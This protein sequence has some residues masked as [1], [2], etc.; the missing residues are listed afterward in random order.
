VSYQKNQNHVKAIECFSKQEEINELADNN[1][2]KA[3]SY[4]AINDIDTYTFYI[5]KAEMKLDLGQKMS[6]GYH[7]ME[8]EIFKSDIVELK[9]SADNKR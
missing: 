7:V 5:D 3:L 6:D 9:K 4:L 8:D 1:Y 2:Y